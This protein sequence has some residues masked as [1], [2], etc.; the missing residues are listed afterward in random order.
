M[1]IMACL[2][3]RQPIAE[4]SILKINSLMTASISAEI[5][6][7]LPEPAFLAIDMDKGGDQL[8]VWCEIRANVTWNNP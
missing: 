4:G 3:T 7:V 5:R 1:F 2:V 6:L 8:T